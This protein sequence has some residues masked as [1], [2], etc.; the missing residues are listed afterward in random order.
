MLTPKTAECVSGRNSRTARFP[1]VLVTDTLVPRPSSLGYRIRLKTTEK[2]RSD[3][4]HWIDA[5][6]VVTPQH[7]LCAKPQSADSIT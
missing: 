2:T 7:A 4:Q 3:G 6:P 1:T 5:I